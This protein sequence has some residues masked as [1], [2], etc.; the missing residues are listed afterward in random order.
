MRRNVITYEEATSLMNP[1]YRKVVAG[2]LWTQ[3]R[4][5]I[6]N[7]PQRYCIAGYMEY[8]NL[9][10]TFWEMTYDKEVKAWTHADSGNVRIELISKEG[11]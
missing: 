10:T 9:G 8:S 7:S 6:P 1:H 4:I 11:R 3:R 2:L 5:S